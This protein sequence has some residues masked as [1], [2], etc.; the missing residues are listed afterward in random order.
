MLL[1]RIILATMFAYLAVY[2]G[3]VIAGHG[4][5]LLPV[6]FGDMG[7]MA[8]PGQFNTGFLAFWFFPHPGSRGETNSRRHPLR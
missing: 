4:W 8:W 5:N 1:F 3:I 6:F 7:T 2:T